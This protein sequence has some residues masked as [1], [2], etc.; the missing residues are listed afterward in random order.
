MTAMVTAHID[1]KNNEG[2][3]NQGSKVSL[4][5]GLSPVQALQPRDMQEVQYDQHQLLPVHIILGHCVPLLPQL[6]LQCCGDSLALLP[7]QVHSDHCKHPEHKVTKQN[8][9]SFIFKEKLI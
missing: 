8:V 1:D 4:V 7:D 9:L 5:S 3:L 2:F 6:I